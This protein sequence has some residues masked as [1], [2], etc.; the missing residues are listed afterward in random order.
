MSAAKPIMELK[1]TL[2]EHPHLPLTR[3]DW[4]LFLMTIGQSN[5]LAEQRSP[6]PAHRAHKRGDAGFAGHGVSRPVMYEYVPYP[7]DPSPAR[8][9]LSDGGRTPGQ[10]SLRAG[11]AS[12]VMMAK[13][14][15]C[16]PPRYGDIAR[17][18]AAGPPL[19]GP[20]RQ[21]NFSGAAAAPILKRISKIANQT[22]LTHLWQTRKDHGHERC[23]R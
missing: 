22:I 14:S 9:A 19:L 13:C 10:H 12:S 4:I 3:D 20:V 8:P 16:R 5:R 2:K 17:H 23:R 15:A 11:A 7:T 6:Q 21:K 18:R 1:N